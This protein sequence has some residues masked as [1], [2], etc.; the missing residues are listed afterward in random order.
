MRQCSR[1]DAA[2]NQT[3]V[4]FARTGARR[5]YPA[6]SLKRQTVWNM[7]PLLVVTAVNV[8]SVPLFYRY[9]GAD[10]YAL[11]FYVITFTG[12]FGFADL[13]LGVAVGRYIGVAIGRG[14]TAAIRE[15]W[16]SGNVVAVPLLAA[17]A[18]AF[19][20]VGVAFGPQ[21]FHVAA[22]NVSLLRGCFVAGAFS[23][24]FS[25]Y[26]QFWNIL[27]QAHLDFKFS[28][29]IRVGTSLLQVL[30]AIV[31]A[32]FTR[33]PLWICIWTALVGA[34]QLAVMAGYSRRVYQ[35]G[36]EWRA[37][38]RERLREMAAYTGK[39]FATLLANSVFGSV[40]RLALGK[41]AAAADFAHYTICSNI[42]G[43][44]Q[45]LSVAVMGPVF[46]NTSRAAGG[47]SRH[48]SAA[49]YD[50]MFHFTFG[51]YLLAALWVATW[52]PVLL[53]VW[54]GAELGG[55][56]APL[57]SP[58]VAAFCLT[59]VASVSGA[60][61][62][63]LNRMGTSLFFTV[64]AG[65]LTVAGVYL[66]WRF[67]GVV[68][69]AYG[70]LASRV[71]YLAQDIYVIRLVKASGWFSRRTWTAVAAQGLIAAGLATA[72]YLFP[73]D[74]LWLLIPA[75]LHIGLVPA[76]LLRHQLSKLWQNRQPV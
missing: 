64:V 76:W 21:W 38:R 25:Y 9:L 13:G 17:M 35:L 6:M 33:S 43:R 12:L 20:T 51:W 67:G 10:L 60:Q 23:L 72:Y 61:L 32:R 19:G 37:A 34:A 54:L 65:L 47:D 1:R 48:T 26:G 5:S 36:F 44:V 73:R 46:H 7:L 16:G 24:F 55:A 66:G 40:D 58:I 53:R 27:L 11:W 62:G 39:T 29:L 22:E 70:F 28:G 15:Y 57:I 75:G 52:H 42:G 3:A 2:R 31:L 56:V 50:E 8:V 18:L 74:S 63:P 59:A 68:G 41:L 71:A 49:I 4:E 69:V 45:S 30:P 14:E